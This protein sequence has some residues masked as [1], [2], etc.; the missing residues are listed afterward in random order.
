MTEI[1]KIEAREILDSRGNPTISVTVVTEGGSGTFEVPSG[2]STGVHEA[3]ELRD[4]DQSHFEGRGVLK[5]VANVA[6]IEPAFIGMNASDQSVIDKKLIELDGTENKSKLGA[7]A[8]LGISVASAKAAAAAKGVEVFEHLRD[9]ASVPPSR[10]TPFL[11]MNLVNGGLHARSRLSFQEYHLVPQSES[12]EESLEIGTGVMHEL[13]KLLVER[14]GASS[15]NIGD[16]GGFAPDLEDIEVPL[17]LLMEASKNTGHDQKIKLALDVAASSF[18][19]DGKYNVG[20][21]ALSAD[22]LAVIYADLANKY[23]ILS[24]EDPFAEESFEDFT[25]LRAAAESAPDGQAKLNTGKFLVIGDD[26]TVTN[27]ERLKKAIEAKSVSGL[28]IKLNQI[29]TLTETIETMQL[30]RANGLECIVSHRSGETND[31]FIADL[32]FAYG[33]FGIKAGAPQRE[34]RVVKY[35][36][37]LKI[38]K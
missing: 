7:N 38:A 36:R 4:G 27:K 1:K 21:K 22:E 31:D 30:A 17:A 5:A 3:L 19:K 16:E 29:G 23:P 34:E 24:I 33:A 32:A 15:A 12:I 6:A 20:G 9:I 25:R 14:Y 35:N 18:C 8:I 26:L 11:Y 13:R 37:L 28:I 10:K 2:A